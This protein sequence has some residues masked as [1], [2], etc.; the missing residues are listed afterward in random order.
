MVALQ[1]LPQ[2]VTPIRRLKR[3]RCWVLLV[4][5]YTIITP[6]AICK[7][8]TPNILFILVDD[9]AW[10]DLGSYNHPWHETPHIDNLAAEGMRFTQAYAPAPIC[11]ASRASILTGKTT[12]RLGFEFVVKSEPGEQV[13]SPPQSLK[14]PPF[15]L[16]LDLDETTIAEILGPGGYETAYFGKWHLNQHYKGVY[17]GWSPTEGPGQQGFFVAEEDFGIHPYSRKEL[18]IIEERGRYH[19]DGLTEKAIGFLERKHEHPFFSWSRIFM[20]IR[21][22]EHPTLGCVINTTRRFLKE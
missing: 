16:A 7:A 8:V 21:R 15:T 20:C 6:P 11:S 18:A 19:S 2:W 12:A 4:L 1:T 14:A 17:N 5:L 10:S 22:F 9:L 13:I 3:Y